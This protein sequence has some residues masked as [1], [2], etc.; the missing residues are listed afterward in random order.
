[1]TRHLT[2]GALGEGRKRQLRQAACCE[3]LIHKGEAIYRGSPC[4]ESSR[5]TDLVQK[6]KVAKDSEGRCSGWT[7]HGL[8][9][10]LLLVFILF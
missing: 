3:H 5:L 8:L 9:P 1:M 10:G 4:P 6:E 2:G 7:G